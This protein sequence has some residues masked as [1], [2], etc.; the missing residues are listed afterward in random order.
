MA[1]TVAGPSHGDTPVILGGDHS[2]T[3]P[4]L[5][6][7]PQRHPDPKLVL[8]VFRAHAITWSRRR[9]QGSWSAPLGHPPCRVDRDHR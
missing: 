8:V 4:I 1:H 2:T 5:R 9:R 7:L 6:G 3:G